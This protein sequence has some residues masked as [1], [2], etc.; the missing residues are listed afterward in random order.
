MEAIASSVIDGRR[1]RGD[2]TRRA[3]LEAAATLASVEGLEGLSIGRLAEHLGISKS[4][5]YAHFRS[6]EELQLAAIRTAAAMYERDIVVPAMQADPGLGRL[7]RFADLFL[8][9]VRNGP[10]PGGCFFIASSLDPARLRGRVRQLL[11]D[12]QRELLNLFAE[13][14]VIAQERGEVDRSLDPERGSFSV[15]AILVGADLNYVLFQDP[16]FLH[17]AGGEVRRM[18]GVADSEPG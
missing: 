12:N 15:D 17:L 1:E 5:L 9:Y 3:I 6:K 11:A 4:G 16:R 18:L 7:L 2:R 8:D 14:I 13:C 10:F